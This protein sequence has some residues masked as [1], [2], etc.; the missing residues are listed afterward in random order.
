M[1]AKKRVVI[2]LIIQILVIFVLVGCTQDSVSKENSTEIETAIKELRAYGELAQKTTEIDSEE[3]AQSLEPI[4]ATTEKP[5]EVVKEEVTEKVVD[6]PVKTNG[7]LE[8]HF[9][10]VGQADASLVICDDK[11]MIIDG[12]NSED[13]SLIYTYLKNRDI[14]HLDYIIS[15]HPHEDHVGGL[16]GALNYAT[17]SKAFS[18]VTSYDSRAFN[19]FIKYL[20]SRTL[21]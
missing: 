5:T 13:S 3:L 16:A 17:V 6:E 7:I 14:D 2:L 9:I 18:P 12:G 10:D 21:E 8:V 20:T 4:V 19:S 1:R 15:T 11:T